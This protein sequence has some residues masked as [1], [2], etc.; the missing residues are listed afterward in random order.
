MVVIPVVV[1]AIVIVVAKTAQQ[2]YDCN[3]AQLPK[4]LLLLVLLNAENALLLYILF[5]T[6][7]CC[8]SKSSALN[9]VALCLW[10][11]LLASNHRVAC[12]LCQHDEQARTAPKLKAPSSDSFGAGLNVYLLERISRLRKACAP[13]LGCSVWSVW[14]FEDTG[15]SRT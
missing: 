2:A 13:V 7:I 4:L 12:G 8:S 3:D 14:G 15:V 5:I 11:G 9:L 1:I 6:A 10:T